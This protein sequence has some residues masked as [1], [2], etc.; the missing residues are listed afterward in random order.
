MLKTSSKENPVYHLNNFLATFNYNP[1]T[2]TLNHQLYSCGP[3][4]NFFGNNWNLI[5]KQF[6]KNGN[7]IIA[8]EGMRLDQISNEFYDTTSLWPVIQ[9]FSPQISNPF[10]IAAG[11]KIFVPNKDEIDAFVSYMNSTNKSDTKNTSSNSNTL[12]F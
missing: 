1:D 10:L 11:T 7:T 6:I 9:L 3:Y 8:T 12:E 5:I 4:I 2:T